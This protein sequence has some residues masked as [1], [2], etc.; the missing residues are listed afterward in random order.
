[1]ANTTQ[2]VLEEVQQAQTVQD[3]AQPEATREG[4]RLHQSQILDELPGA[5]FA[6][7]TLVWIF[8]SFGKLIW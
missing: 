3:R 6:A 2:Q 5:A 7:M 4:F 8:T 1:M